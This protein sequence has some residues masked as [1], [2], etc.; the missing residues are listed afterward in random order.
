MPARMTVLNS[1]L[2]ENQTA[3]RKVSI[4]LLLDMAREKKKEKKEKGKKACV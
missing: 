2:F 3:A 4:S 1:I